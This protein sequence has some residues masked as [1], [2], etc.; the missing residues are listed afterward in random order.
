VTNSVCTVRLSSADLS[1]DH[2]ASN[3]TLISTILFALLLSIAFVASPNVNGAFAQTPQTV[4]TVRLIGDIP[5]IDLSRF[6]FAPPDSSLYME[7]YFALRNQQQFKRRIF[8]MQDFQSS[9]MGSL[10]LKRHSSPL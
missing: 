10:F 6:S 7:I 3:P 1:V 9:S 5:T 2:C 4:S 8:D